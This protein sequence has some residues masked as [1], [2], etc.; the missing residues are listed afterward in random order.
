M[1]HVVNIPRKAMLADSIGFLS[2]SPLQNTIY[3]LKMQ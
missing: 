1:D 3:H 2:L